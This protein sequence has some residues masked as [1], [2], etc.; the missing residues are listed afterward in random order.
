MISMTA[1][2]N[3]MNL[4]AMIGAERLRRAGIV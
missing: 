2:H 1:V 4:P 3:P